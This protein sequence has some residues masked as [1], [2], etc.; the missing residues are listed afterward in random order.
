MVILMITASLE[1]HAVFKDDL[2]KYTKLFHYTQIAVH[3]IKAKSAILAAHML[4]Y[5]LRRQIS[6]VL[7]E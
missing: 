3:G 5:I 7:A 1:F 2:F 6:R 4:I